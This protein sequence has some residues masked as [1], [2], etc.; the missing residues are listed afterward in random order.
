MLRA[1]GNPSREAGASS[2]RAAVLHALATLRRTSVDAP[3]LVALP[4]SAIVGGLCIRQIFVATG[5][6]CTPIDD[7]FIH[8]QFARR[9]SEGS[10][11]CYA[12]GAPSS[13]G[14]TS[15]LFPLLLAPFYKIGLRDL[16]LLWAAWAIGL[17]AHA[18]VA[19]E[20]QR[21]VRRLASDGA[22]LAAGLLCG[23]FGGYAWHAYSGMETML[24]AW[25]L[26]ATVRRC[27]Q[28]CEPTDERYEPADTRDRIALVACGFFA[29]LVRPEGSLASLFAAAALAIGPRPARA[30][31]RL[32]GL[33]P[34]AGVLALPGLN[35]AL[36]GRAMSSTAVTKW[37]WRSPYLTT[38]QIIDKI[39]NNV[40][41]LGSR[42]LDGDAP[43][44]FLPR[45]AAIVFALGL[46]ALGRSVRRRKLVWHGV[47]VALLLLGILAPCTYRGFDTHRGRYLWP[48]AS[49]LL[50]GIGCLVHEAG[51]LGGRWRPAAR[52]IAQG[53][54]GALCALALAA[55]LGHAVVDLGASARAISRQQVELARWAAAMLPA[56]ARLGVND[57]GALGY[58]SERPVFDLIGLV[59][60]EEARYWAAG[61]GSRYEHYERMPRERLPTHFIVYPGWVG[62]PMLF[63]PELARAT[64]ADQSILG[65]ETM[66]AFEARYDV[67]G[68]GA[69]PTDPP[70]DRRLVDE[71]DV[72]DL[73]SE[74]LHGYAP[75]DLGHQENRVDE[76]APHMPRRIVDAGRRFRHKDQFRLRAPSRAAWL[77]LRVATSS[78]VDLTV[79]AEGRFVAAVHLEPGPWQEPAVRLGNLSGSDPV[80]VEVAAEGRERFASY[81][82]WL[83]EDA[84]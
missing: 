78:P 75:G 15:R 80:G 54:L 59:T 66:I 1:G 77:V 26:L 29:P 13:T 43:G 2:G 81:H 64:V 40:W 3:W 57:A 41:I 31:D 12:A 53:A 21:L 38:V 82:Y 19:V 34:V 33:V 10:L 4:V 74:A 47:F 52:P 36:T 23:L 22:A 24:L 71:L 30:S 32:L 84:P 67:L 9:L 79:K 28:W 65:A 58:L 51:E 14:A 62:H 56:G 61:E 72:S 70:R 11:Y 48:F 76:N 6:P 44:H 20:T 8:L 42:V 37:L 7:A 83:Y 50:V 46:V 18:G 16:S 39:A 17:F 69:L 45:G 35:V 5:G 55:G 73:E 27:A 63:G 60:D 49:A 25:I 68:S